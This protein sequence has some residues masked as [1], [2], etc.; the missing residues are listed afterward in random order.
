[1][2]NQILENLNPEQ[3]AACKIINGPILILAGAGTG[4]TRTITHRIAY[5]ISQNI[6]P[7][8]ILAITFTNKAAEVMKNRTEDLLTNC[9][10]QVASYKLRAAS[11]RLPIMGTFHS[12]CGRVL[13]H[14]AH[15]LGYA[16]SFTIYDDGDQTHIVKRVLESLN[17]SPKKFPPPMILSLI[18]SA[19]VE[20]VDWKTYQQKYA[21]DFLTKI[22][23]QVYEKYTA[24]LKKNMAMDFDDLIYNTVLLFQK[25]PQVLAK[26]QERFRYILVDEY[27]DTNHLEYL[28]VKLLAQKYRNLCVCGDDFQS[29]Y[30]WR[31]ADVQNILNFEKDFSEVKIIKLEENYRSTQ[32]VLDAADFV[33]K[34]NTAQKD[35]TLWT[36]KKEGP[37]VTIHESRDSRGEGEFIVTEIE[38]LCEEF[39]LNYRDCA[40]LYRLHAQSRAIEEVLLDYKIPYRIIGG[41]RFYERKEIKDIIAFLRLILNPSD[42]VAFRRVINEPTKGLGE[43]TI[44]KLEEFAETRKINLIAGCASAKEANGIASKA[45]LTLEKFA[46]MYGE[47]SKEYNCEPRGIHGYPAPYTVQGKKL[48]LADL[49]KWVAK[50]TGY[51]EYVK[52]GTIEGEARW[53]NI[54]ELFTLALKYK[55]NEN[56]LQAFLE[57]VALFSETEEYVPGDNKISLM[58]LHSAK[59]LEFEAVFM[60]G[61]EENL[62]PHSKS[63]LEMPQ[64]EEERRL[65]YVGMTRAKKFLYLLHTISRQMF[66]KIINNPISRFIQEMPENLAQRKRRRTYL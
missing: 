41:V 13:R 51:E 4:K 34:Q 14:E 3:Q 47:F 48:E 45:A 40:I 55:E 9:R 60:P 32:R 1:M 64:L 61:L 16:R 38:R 6:K 57:E 20:M 8:D 50:K 42:V 37:F 63:M 54:E 28:L 24:F 12:F 21:N 17:L 35:K 5:L 52:D 65:C 44:G 30:G 39:S 33:I 46:K 26:Y 43:K 18:S 22:V 36:K 58:T 49:I 31:N 19:K 62:L 53:E 23:S 59:G 11:R 7:E 29:I 2:A 25:F 27:Q 66:G 56:A 15:H 10:L